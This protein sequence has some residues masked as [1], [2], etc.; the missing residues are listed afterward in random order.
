MTT[1][2]TATA[3]MESLPNETKPT[4]RPRPGQ[5]GWLALTIFILLHVACLAVIF[6]GT[7]PTALILCGIVYVVQMF[8][9]TAGYHR[10]FSHR[11]FKTS[12]WFQFVLGWLGC[13]AGQAGPLWWASVH[14]NHHRTSVLR[15]ICI[16]PSSTVSGGPMRVGS[17]RKPPT[18][19]MRNRLKI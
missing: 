3:S 6:S 8:G 14:R 12:R 13:S 17:C 15:K 9:I 19:R 11:S 1:T 4:T 2:T 16:P 18:R 10:Y 7:T 5:I